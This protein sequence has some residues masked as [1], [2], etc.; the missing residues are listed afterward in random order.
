[1]KLPT[2]PPASSEASP[3]EETT[4]SSITKPNG[5]EFQK[6]QRNLLEGV[7]REFIAAAVGFADTHEE[8]IAS[9]EQAH[10]SNEA[11]PNAEAWD[12]STADFPLDIEKTSLDRQAPS[13]QEITA[14]LA[15]RDAAQQS[16]LA[17]RDAAQQSPLAQRDAAQQVPLPVSEVALDK[18]TQDMRFPSEELARFLARQPS[19]QDPHASLLQGQQVSASSSQPQLSSSHASDAPIPAYPPTVSHPSQSPPLAAQGISMRVVWLIAVGC[20]IAGGLGTFLLTRFWP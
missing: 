2:P 4:E 15:Q 7:P 17:Q 10:G 12:T 18:T 6:T 20:L 13:M 1:V 16:P 14:F 3:A 19:V 11:A 5:F 9:N 8:P